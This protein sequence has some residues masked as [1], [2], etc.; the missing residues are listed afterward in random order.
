LISIFPAREWHEEYGSIVC[1]HLP[2][3]LQVLAYPF[4]PILFF[5]EKPN[6]LNEKVA[7]L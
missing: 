1:S 6:W 5:L 4:V 7:Y 3:P 2:N